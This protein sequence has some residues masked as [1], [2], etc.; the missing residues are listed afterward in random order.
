M[1]N[2]LKYSGAYYWPEKVQFWMPSNKPGDPNAPEGTT[3]EICSHGKFH[4][5]VQG[6][7]PFGRGNASKIPKDARALV[8]CPDFFRN[9][10]REAPFKEGL[11]AER[12]ELMSLENALLDHQTSMPG[13]LLQA[14]ASH[15]EPLGKTKF[16]SHNL[17]MIL[18]SYSYIAAWVQGIS[19]LWPNSPVGRDG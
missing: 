5:N 15:V 9:A 19:P 1:T 14:L 18:M 7:S 12:Q 2:N 6:R 10:E 17:Y 3:S 16:Y 8:L 4:M 11:K 13:L